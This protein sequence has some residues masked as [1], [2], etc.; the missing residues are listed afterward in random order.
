MLHAGGHGG[1]I[2]GLQFAAGHLAAAH[3]DADDHNGRVAVRQ[4]PSSCA[5]KHTNLTRGEVA[6]APE[7]RTRVR[8]HA[9]AKRTQRELVLPDSSE[10]DV[11]Q[12]GVGG[13]SRERN[14]GDR[15][16][17]EDTKVVDTSIVDD[18]MVP[19][20]VDVVAH[21]AANTTQA[22]HDAHVAVCYREG[23]HGFEDMRVTLSRVGIAVTGDK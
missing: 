10:A 4:Q 17:A 1:R 7:G 14:A 5:V 15:T 9:Q 21:L 2:A 6:V 19:D 8:E 3:R 11:E 23:E 13:S 22:R 16:I 18:G 20:A 12:R